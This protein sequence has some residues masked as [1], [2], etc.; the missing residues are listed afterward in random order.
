V[1]DTDCVAVQEGDFCATGHIC[2]NAVISVRAEAQYE[3]DLRSKVDGTK[4]PGPCPRGSPG[5][6]DHGECTIGPPGIGP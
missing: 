6:C 3:S 2:P 5:V 1:V 4:F